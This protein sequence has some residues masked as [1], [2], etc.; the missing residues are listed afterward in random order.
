MKVTYKCKKC[1]SNEINYSAAALWDEQEQEW[2]VDELVDGPYC[3]E[4][5]SWDIEEVEINDEDDL[6][7]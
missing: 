4:C 2:V 6:D 3:R 5:E 7:E 1:G